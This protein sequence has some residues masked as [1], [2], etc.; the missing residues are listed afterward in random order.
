LVVGEHTAQRSAGVLL[1]VVS[2]L[3]PF[4]S[5]VL[6][7]TTPTATHPTA[8]L[9]LQLQGRAGILVPSTTSR[10]AQ[11]AQ[12]RRGGQASLPLCVSDLRSVAFL[13]E[14][15]YFSHITTL[16]IRV[17][18]WE[19]EEGTMGLVLSHPIQSSNVF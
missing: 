13:L 3:S 1:L 11:R 2:S 10:E 6:A 15:I 18:S 17:M 16:K 5:L 9:Q 4:P 7:F 8:S 12:F 19:I 14:L